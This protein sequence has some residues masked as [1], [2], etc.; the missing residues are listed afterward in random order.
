MT[1][2]FVHEGVT[3]VLRS[4]E[5][6]WLALL[7]PLFVWVLARSLAGLRFHEKLLSLLLRL[8]FVLVLLVGLSRVAREIRSEKVF[9]VFLVDVSDSMTDEAIADAQKLLDEA[10]EAKGDGDQLRVL[11][12]GAR[13]EL[14]PTPEDAETPPR[15]ARLRPEMA[16]GT[17]V[18][19]AMQLAQGLYPPGHLRRMVLVSDGIET[20]GDMLAE[21]NRLRELGI[22][23]FTFANRR[24]GPREIAVR[25]LHV[26]DRVKVGEPFELRA[27]LYASQPGQARLRLLQG[28]MLNGLDGIKTVELVPGPNEIVFRSVVRL[29]GEVTYELQVE[30]LTEDTFADNNRFEVT[31]DVPGRPSVLYVEGEPARAGPLARALESQGFE[32]DVRG[33]L[34]FPASLKELERF[35][36]FVLSDVPARQVS[37]SSQALIERY[38]REVGGGFLYAGG[39]NGY[40]PGGWQNSIVERL[41]PVR[42][43]A[44][45]QKEM[46]TVALALVIDRSGSMSGMPMEMAKEA[47][48][49]TV[50][51][52]APDDRIGVIAFDSAPVR[53]VKMQPAR[54]RSRIK[55]DISRI[56]A[57]GGTE[58]FPALD[59]AYQDLAVTEARRKH[60]I[61]LT[62]G[63]APS[64]GIRDLVQAMAAEA[65]TV[66]TVGL[67][68]EVDD[69]LL[70]T[71]KDYGG[72]R[73][74][75]VPDASSLPRIFTREAEMV[76]KSATT[77]DYFP[78]QQTAPASFLRGI[79]VS[80]AP[81]LAGYTSTGLKPPPAQQIL[82]NPDH[83]EPVLARWR[84][85]LGWSIAWTSDVKARWAADW[86]RWAGWPKFW[87]QL[88]REH[89]RQRHGHELP[90]QVE[91][92]GSE[93]RASVDAYTPDDR[94]DNGLTSTLIVLGPRTGEGRREV[95]MRQT[96]PGRYEARFRLDQYGAFVLR[97][98]H[99]KESEDGRLVPFAVSHGHVAHPYPRE[100]ASFE[101][102]VAAL[103]ALAKATSGAPSPELDA[104]FDPAGESV[105]SDEELWPRFAL[106]AIALLVLDIFV[107]RVRIFG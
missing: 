2:S 63:R 41:L 45:K 11:V 57:G 35:D 17:N 102:D 95:A 84:V 98:E 36:F 38:L 68:P 48:K 66:T 92:V 31:I 106:A 71:I 47:A 91:I 82:T 50:D 21:A 46:P 52:L 67:G 69:G 12:F 86:A 87:G 43:Q 78:V 104:L 22:K 59:A 44:E 10:W 27:D 13:P 37:A 16:S 42:A 73:Y 7:L 74:H 32:V 54:N 25:E 88:V 28:E 53:A 61:L 83:G 58:I 9:T 20:E 6:L 4:P 8:A 34:A 103:D 64:G 33:P 15:L 97:A 30:P 3:Y 24:P 39:P 90:M 1:P 105:T 93:V 51:T 75:K 85:G 70:T 23:L 62:D 96:G 60:V 29:P 19:A 5:W 89:M 81:F 101:A 18:Q 99:A 107:R 56:Q 26:P 55:G 100:Y 94:F 80:A 49:A 14:V 76:A 79:D 77:L 65:I 40:G 72:G